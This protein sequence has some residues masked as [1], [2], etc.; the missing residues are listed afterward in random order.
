MTR[1]SK[2]AYASLVALACWLAS[3]PA[4]AEP[5]VPPPLVLEAP[6][7]TPADL[8]ARVQLVL[9]PNTVAATVLHGATVRV[10]PAEHEHE[11]EIVLPARGDQAAITRTLRGESCET[12]VDATILVIGLWVSESAQAAPPA[13]PPA[14]PP[15][16]PEDDGDLG[17][18]HVSIRLG[19]ALGS[20]MLP[21]TAWG[22]ELGGALAWRTLRLALVGRAWPSQSSTRV[23]A[24]LIEGSLRIA[25]LPVQLGALQLGPSAGLAVGRLHVEGVDVV[26]S[27]QHSL[28]WWRSE[29]AALVRWTMQ[30][31][32]LAL[33]LEAGGAL[34]WSRP[35]VEVDGQDT[36]FRPAGL[37]PFAVI[38]LELVLK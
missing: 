28:L 27:K 16:M 1:P 21:A 34:P 7:I 30:G 23:A 18:L 4:A 25:W 31:V 37:S 32:P 13:P 15:P 26:D 33:T 2:A 14:P 8:E 29:V 10:R 5:A 6:C 9:P 20:A 24:D 38:G 17:P 19:A 3:E 12:V 11:V 36:V 35:Y 22:A